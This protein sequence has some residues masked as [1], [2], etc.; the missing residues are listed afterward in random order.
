MNGN[1]V[2]NCFDELPAK[3]LQ[4]LA[5]FFFQQVIHIRSKRVDKT[6]FQIIADRMDVIMGGMVKEVNGG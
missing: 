5:A 1:L 3:Y 4:L 6:H 2:L